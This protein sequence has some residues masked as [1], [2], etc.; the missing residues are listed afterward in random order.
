MI[1]QL[2]S[3]SS[4]F[5]CLDALSQKS[6]ARDT[7]KEGGFSSLAVLSSVVLTILRFCHPLE[8]RPRF[9]GVCSLWR[10]A[11]CHPALKRLVLASQCMDAES[12]APLAEYAGTLWPHRV[13]PS[14]PQA[15]DLCLPG[16][17]VVVARGSHFCPRP[18]VVTRPVLVLAEG[19]RRAHGAGQKDAEDDAWV[20]GSDGM[21][22]V[23]QDEFTTALKKQGKVVAPRAPISARNVVIE[24]TEDDDG[25]GGSVDCPVIRMSSAMV[26]QSRGGRV[27]GLSL[28]N[29]NSH[30][31]YAVHV[32][33]GCSATFRNCHLSNY[34]GTGSCVAV[35]TNGYVVLTSCRLVPGS[36]SCV[37]VGSGNAI[38]NRC[39]LRSQCAAGVSV[40]CGCAAMRQCMI[41]DVSTVGVRLFDADSILIAKQNKFQKAGVPAWD[42]PLGA[43]RG[44]IQR[45]DNVV[46]TASGQCSVEKD[47]SVPDVAP[48]SPVTMSGT[49][50]KVPQVRKTL[51]WYRRPGPIVPPKTAPSPAVAA[52]PVTPRPSVVTQ[53]RPLPFKRDNTPP[54]VAG[55]GMVHPRPVMQSIQPPPGVP[56]DVYMQYVMAANGRYFPVPTAA[57]QPRPL[58]AAPQLVSQLQPPVLAPRPQPHAIG[59]Q[60]GHPVPRMPAPV[61]APPPRPVLVAPKRPSI[62]WP[63]QP[64]ITRILA[65]NGNTTGEGPADPSHEP[66]QD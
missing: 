44:A 39:V 14:L 35:D 2:P 1:R 37:F 50:L 56:M 33:P 41:E 31:P 18:V 19:D 32:L 13:F 6:E 34:S 64:A 43:P 26:W 51:A 65:T 22:I 58:M 49:A 28:R 62:V 63:A 30:V 8:D 3:G 46:T 52:R 25:V 5:W 24:A 9:A 4:S 10:K 61:V 16:E 53:P 29:V 21:W 45:D 48:F 47:I 40:L 59:T 42:L 54:M 60:A 20:L 27:E 11:T 66:D 15:L 17:V 23:V 38:L 12:C 7:A 57:Q 36:G 55:Y